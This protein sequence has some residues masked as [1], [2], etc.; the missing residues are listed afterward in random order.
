MNLYDP[1]L[2]RDW[3][4]ASEPF[5]HAVINGLW[6]DAFLDSVRQEFPRPEDPRWKTYADLEEVG[7]KALDEPTAWGTMTQTFFQTIVS[8]DFKQDL[9]RLTGIEDL[10]GDAIGGGLHETGEG[11]KLGM[12]VDFNYHPHTGQ[13]RR[14]NVLTFLNYEWDCAWGGCLYLGADR[15]L[16]IEPAFN[17]TVIFQCSNESWHGHPDPIVG[18]HYRQ[19]LAA[20]F[21]TAPG[22]VDFGEAH[23]TIYRRD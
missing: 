23:T 12:H 22:S 3:M 2:L 8:A 4:W 15:D 10:W 16:C 6:E 19:S 21:Y 11:G 7:K 17:R 18:D 9:T 1:G 5:P 20:Y 13:P 14:L